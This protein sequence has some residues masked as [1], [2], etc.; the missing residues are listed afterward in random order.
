MPH[1]GPPCNPTFFDHGI[2]HDEHDAES[3]GYYWVVVRGRAPL[4]VYL[5]LDEARSKVEGAH[6]AEWKKFSTKAEALEYWNLWCL[7]LHAHEPISYKVKGL[8]GV[9]DK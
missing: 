9:F 2:N 7:R 1:Q 3:R 6:N 4:G 8:P 5:V